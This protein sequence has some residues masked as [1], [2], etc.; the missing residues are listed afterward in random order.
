MKF[1]RIKDS[2]F[3]FH[4]ELKGPDELVRSERN[5]HNNVGPQGQESKK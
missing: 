1:S 5:V 3:T 4:Y 2:D